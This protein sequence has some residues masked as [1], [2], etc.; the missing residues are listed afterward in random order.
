M[1]TDQVWQEAGDPDC[2]CIGCLE[3]RVDRVVE[4]ADFPPIPLNDDV[5]TDSVRLRVRKG[6]GRSTYAL[7]GLAQRA[8]LD[9]GVN[10]NTAASALGLDASLLAIWVDGGLREL[11]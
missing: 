1:V 4:P 10:L 8:I 11:A 2:L 6:S 7:Y 5:E 3:E 9:L